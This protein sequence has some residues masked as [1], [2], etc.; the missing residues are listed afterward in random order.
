M[1]QAKCLNYS[2]ALLVTAA[3]S[4]AFAPLPVM[5]TSITAMSTVPQGVTLVEVVRELPL[6]QPE[7]LWIRPGDS[8]G[9]TLF[10]YSA[11]EVGVSRC[12]AECAQE[13]PP[14]VAT[15]DSKPDGDWSLVQRPDGARQWAYQGRPLYTW[16]QEKKP[17][18]VATNVGLTETANAKLAETAV[19]A[20]SLLPPEEWRVARFEP[21]AGIL[22]PDGIVVEMVPSAHAV[23]LT[24]FNGLTLYTFNG[25]AKDDG[26]VCSSAGCTMQWH[27]VVAPALAVT[28]GEFSI[29]SRKDGSRQWAYRGRPLYT[30]HGDMLPGD[31]HG[32]TVDENW[33]V[34]VLT[35]NFQPPQVTVTTVPGYGDLLSLNG[36]T[37]YAG[38]AFE[39]RWGGRNLRDTFRNAYYQGKDLGGAA[40]ADAQCLRSW[41]PFEAP[42]DAQANGFWEPILRANGSKQWAYKGNALYTFAGDSAPGDMTGHSIYDF[43]KVGG[44]EDDL[45][46]IAFLSEITGQNGG[47]GIYWHIAKP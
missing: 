28:V 17:G 23:A 14:L 41:R 27:P 29:V 45:K 46:R 11:D 43:A 22:L 30:Y 26:Q 36:M 31:V 12:T 9:R 19:E 44:N 25:D 42:A 39:K 1:L 8:E 7:R 21:G 4:I 3:I 5:A 24:D 16:V 33:N 15:E 6:S 47:A 20:G 32:M 10:V 13:F 34:A 37:L 38:H 2:V 40:C 18:E 35:E